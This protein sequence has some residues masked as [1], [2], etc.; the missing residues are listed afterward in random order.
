MKQ[1]EFER[2]A[3]Q[4]CSAREAANRYRSMLR[5]GAC[6]GV[7]A[8]PLVAGAALFNDGPKLGPITQRTQQSQIPGMSLT[9]ARAAGLTIFTAQFNH[10]DGYGDGP[11]ENYADPTSHNIGNT[12]RPTLQNNGTFLRVNGLDSQTCFE[13]HAQVSS[14]TTPLTP[15]LGG[16]G[17]IN[18][19][20]MF[21]PTVID[22]SDSAH[23]G[24]AEFNGRLI[25]PPDLFGVGGVQLLGQE[26]TVALQ[27]EKTFAQAHPGQVVPLVAKGISFGSIAFK[28]GQFDTSNVEGVDTD[29]VVR[30]FGRKGDNQTIR[31]FDMGATQ[32]HLGMQPE[33]VVGH[34]VDADGDGTVNELL[35]GEM[36][37]L[38]IFLTTQDTTFEQR[39]PGV[40]AGRS[41]F[42]FVGCA[43]C[44]VPELD[45]DSAVLKYSFPEDPI[46]PDANVFYQVDLRKGQTKFPPA[47]GGGIRV[48]AFSDLKRH[49]MGPVLAE[50]FFKQT[51]KQNS[52]F[53]TA[54]LWGVADS[55]P[56]L[57]D[58][59]ALT[60]REAIELH[61]GEAQ[62]A[63]DKF[64]SL[65]NLQKDLILRF[66]NSLKNPVN[67]DADVSGNSKK[68]RFTAQSDY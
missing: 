22:V 67:P 50:T 32:F 21:Q 40:E 66:L 20:P 27:K 42:N 62:A 65:N 52:E 29:L 6:F 15:G 44:H 36:S 33:E 3:N 9:E 28:N 11:G 31:D 10:A 41:L 43:S 63:R 47:R 54:K 24:F 25:N 34:N 4:D 58:G 48:Q 5:Y 16:H 49:D 7:A 68:K 60:L 1:D 18:A 59:R 2:R 14:A 64:V 39:G 30:P 38:E 55:G 19:S 57:H 53:I 26:M 23:K 13:C 51:P 61:G 12:G 35:D 8:L 17:G 45:T 56:Y 46:N 37:A